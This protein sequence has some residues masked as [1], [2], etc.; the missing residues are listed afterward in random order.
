ML[1]GQD[2]CIRFAPSVVAGVF[3]RLASLGLVVQVS[4]CGYEVAAA[5]G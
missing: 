1:V 2:E 5:G 3:E 4:A